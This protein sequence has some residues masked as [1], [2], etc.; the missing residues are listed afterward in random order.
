ML[1]LLYIPIRVDLSYSLFVL[2]NSQIRATEINA[3]KLHEHCCN[4]LGEIGSNMNLVE[5]KKSNQLAK[6]LVS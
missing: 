1:S 6:A 4:K 3:Q 2:V 5:I